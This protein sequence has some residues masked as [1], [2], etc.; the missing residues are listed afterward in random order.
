MSKAHGDILFLRQAITLASQAEKDGNLPIG[1][2]ITLDGRVIASGRNSI[3]SPKLR[4]D[5][6]AEMEALRS[7]PV[8]ARGRFS[9]M[10]LYTTLEPCLMCAGAILLHRIGRVVFGAS[11]GYGGATTTF[12]RMPPFFQEALTGTQWIGPLLPDECDRLARRATELEA[13]RH[14]RQEEPAHR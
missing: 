2:V 12:G 1:A 9:E 3:W 7:V 10:T 5:C 11:D 14:G 6:H 13:G 4:L 8:D